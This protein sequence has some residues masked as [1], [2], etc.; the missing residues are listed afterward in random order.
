MRVNP[1]LIIAAY[2]IVRTRITVS[3][4]NYARNL[5]K[6]NSLMAVYVHVFTVFVRFS[7]IILFEEF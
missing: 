2:F 1:D 7:K 6:A 4:T 3:V 5:A